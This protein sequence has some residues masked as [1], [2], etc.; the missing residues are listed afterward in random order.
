MYRN[1]LRST[2]GL[3]EERSI[4]TSRGVLASL[5]FDK[6]VWL[7]SSELSPVHFVQWLSSVSQG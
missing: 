2:E 7:K 6:L 3:I 5:P 1:E 4:G